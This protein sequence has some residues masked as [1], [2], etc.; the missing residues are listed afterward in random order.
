VGNEQV[1]RTLHEQSELI[2]GRF[3]GRPDFDGNAPDG[4]IPQEGT[5]VRIEMNGDPLIVPEDLLRYIDHTRVSPPEAPIP[6]FLAETPHYCWIRERLYV[7]GNVLDVGANLGLFALM[8]AKKIKY[9]PTGWVHAFEPSPTSRR[10]LTRM[11]AC[12]QVSNVSVQAMA[13]S[14]RCGKAVFNDI[15]TENVTREASHLIECG[16]QGFTTPLPQDRIEVDTIDLD[17]FTERNL[18]YPQLIK[19]D[20]EGAEFL[21]LEGARRCIERHRPLLVI[22]IHPNEAGEFDSERLH[23]YLDQYGY[24]YHRQGKIYYCE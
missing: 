9:G 20:V 12:N 22:E 6:L 11:L 23:K 13:A 24:R 4:P 21:V 14:D 2:A 18:I 19:I 16:C 1:M 7:G 15:Q 10:D 17:T 3:G 8:M 5:D